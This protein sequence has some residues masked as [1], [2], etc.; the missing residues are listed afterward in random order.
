M[1]IDLNYIRN[2]SIISHIDHGKTKLS[3]CLVSYTSSYNKFNLVKDIK[4]F[5]FL[6]TEQRRGITI[7]MHY[8]RMKY[9]NYILNLIDTPGHSDFSFEIYRSLTISDGV[10]LLIDASKGAQAQTLYNKKIADNLNLKIIPVIS[11]IDISNLSLN[12]VYND[13]ESLGFSKNEILNISSK[14]NLGIKDLLDKIVGDIPCPQ[15]LKSLYGSK[16]VAKIFNIEFNNYFGLLLHVK[17]LNGYIQVGD[18]LVIFNEAGVLKNNMFRVIDLG[19]SD[20][21]NEKPSVLSAGELGCLKINFKDKTIDNFNNMI[22]NIIISKSKGYLENDFREL[23]TYTRDLNRQPSVFYNIYPEVKNQFENLKKSLFKIKAQDL[24]LSVEQITCSLG[25]SLKCGF[26]GILHFE[27]I[28]EQLKTEFGLKIYTSP[29]SLIYKAVSSKNEIFSVV[30][31]DDLEKFKHSQFELRE[32]IMKVEIKTFNK[33]IGN[34]ITLITRKR[35][36]TYDINYSSVTNSNYTDGNI[37]VTINALMPMAEVLEN[38]ENDLKNISNGLSTLSY[39]LYSYIKAD[40]QS[41]RVKINDIEFDELALIVHK[42]SVLDKAKSL[43]ERLKKNIQRR[44]FNVKIQFYSN[45]KVILRD[46]IK[47]LRKDVTAKCY[48]GDISRKKKL[49]EKQKSGKK[50]LYNV[51]SSNNSASLLTQEVLIKSIFKE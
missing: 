46:N 37:S 10:V 34:I 21:L 42:K 48:G 2:F 35:F 18:E 5:D 45:G 36:I 43:V 19:F 12:R 49:I 31:A 44:L 33:F 50:K 32:P 26:L 16:L 14:Q 9:N 23:I 15:N 29:P 1:S 24:S 13:F 51:S 40:L 7:K 30:N 39:K 8:I 28:K 17:V 4:F 11:K 3:E 38:F 22:G 6:E 41:L 27:I 25:Y 20:I 47:P